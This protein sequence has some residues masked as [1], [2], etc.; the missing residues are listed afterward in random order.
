MSSYF[1]E[2]DCVPLADGAAPDQLLQFARQ[3]HHQHGLFS[4]FCDLALTGSL[5]PRETGTTKNLPPYFLTDHLLLHLKILSTI[6]PPECCE[7]ILT[8]S[9]LFVWKSWSKMTS[10][11]SYHVI[12]SSTV[13]VSWPGLV[14]Q[15]TALFVGLYINPSLSHDLHCL[16]ISAFLKRYAGSIFFVFVHGMNISF[17]LK[18]NGPFHS[19]QNELVSPGRNGMDNN[20]LIP[21][22]MDHFI[23]AKVN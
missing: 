19:S 7:M 14:R 8:L 4:L 21:A 10:L 2:H 20:N 17:R 5:W 11:L 13:S 6:C 18:W 3:V 1:D 23:P 22:W 16:S 15:L 9:A 12:M